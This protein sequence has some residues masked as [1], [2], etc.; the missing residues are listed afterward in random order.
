MRLTS[1]DKRLLREQLNR[2]IQDTQGDGVKIKEYAWAVQW[3][4]G[5]TF[6]EIADELGMTKSHIAQTVSKVVEKVK[7][8]TDNA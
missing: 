8:F 1:K 2:F 7:E 4:E 6:Q 3:S 5:M